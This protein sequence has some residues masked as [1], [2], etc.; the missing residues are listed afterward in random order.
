[1]DIYSIL[2]SKPH[3]SH[4]L[5]CYITFIRKCQLKNIGYEGYAEKH[6]ICPKA[7]DMFPEYKSFSKNPWNKALLTPRQHFIAHLMLWLS[8]RNKS[9]ANTIACFMKNNCKNSKLY[10][11]AKT[12]Y[13]KEVSKRMKNKAVVK[14]LSGN[15]LQISVNNEKYLNGEFN[16]IGKNKIMTKDIDGNIFKIDKDD[17]RFLRGELV[18]MMKGV[19]GYKWTEEQKDKIRG[20]NNKGFRGKNHSKD[21]KI[22]MS[23]SLKG[24]TANWN[25]VKCPYCDK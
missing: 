19:G 12:E 1:M 6:H 21:T 20:E 25:K 11:Q 17:P 23:N 18:G 15:I 13:A 3:N 16:S 8:Y 2:A 24:K 4:H 14:D 9:S 22:K 10:A 5:N 7:K